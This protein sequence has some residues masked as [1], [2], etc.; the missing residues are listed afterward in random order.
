MEHGNLAQLCRECEQNSGSNPGNKPCVLNI[1]SV[2]WIKVCSQLHDRKFL[3]A[4][5]FPFPVYDV[6]FTA[7]PCPACSDWCSVTSD[8]EFVP[9]VCLK[10]YFI[11][12]I[13][14]G[15]FDPFRNI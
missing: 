14:I 9:C 6:T 5:L 3:Q 12:L 4:Y 2:V 11:L 7:E 13:K 1:L 10:Y 15:R 8:L